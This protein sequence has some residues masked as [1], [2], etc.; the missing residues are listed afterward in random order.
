MMGIWDK[1]GYIIYINI[2]KLSYTSCQYSIVEQ[3][4]VTADDWAYSAV[5]SMEV[6]REQDRLAQAEQAALA[7]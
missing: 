7:N 3:C 1:H 4:T 5:L 6:L 2:Y